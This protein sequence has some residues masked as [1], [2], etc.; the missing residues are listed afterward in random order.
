MPPPYTCLLSLRPHPLVTSW[1]EINSTFRFSWPNRAMGEESSKQATCVQPHLL[2][3]EQGWRAAR[4]RE[5]LNSQ[6][7]TCVLKISWARLTEILPST[8][9]Q[10]ILNF[11]VYALSIIFHWRLLWLHLRSWF[12]KPSF[13]SREAIF[14]H[15]KCKHNGSSGVREEPCKFNRGSRFVTSSSKSKKKFINSAANK[16][17]KSNG[18]LNAR[19]ELRK[20]ICRHPTIS[21]KRFT[22]IETPGFNNTNLTPS[23]SDILVQ[24]AK[25][26]KKEWVDLFCF[27]CV[28]SHKA[29]VQRL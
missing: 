12:C 9:L 3:I 24:T 17:E 13:A 14:W 2:C 23:D 10:R 28:Q 7:F 20:T 5:S 1:I 18:G 26:M 21:S 25:L 22:L 4:N 19:T 8:Y 16:D 15:F 6:H 11:E 29:Q 27:D